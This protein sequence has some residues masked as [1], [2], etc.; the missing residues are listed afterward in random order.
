VAPEDGLLMSLE[1]LSAILACTLLAGLA[2]FPERLI[3]TP[4]TLVLAALYL[5][6]SLH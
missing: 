6:I 5:V 1:Q 2:I 4:A 3:M